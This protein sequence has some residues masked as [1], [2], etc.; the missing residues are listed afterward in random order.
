MKVF[1]NKNGKFLRFW[2]R[3]KGWKGYSLFNYAW[4]EDINQATICESKPH[5]DPAEWGNRDCPNK[6]IVAELEATRKVTIE[7]V[8]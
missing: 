7:L 3:E 6:D 1:I 5:T 8:N 2:S 4:V